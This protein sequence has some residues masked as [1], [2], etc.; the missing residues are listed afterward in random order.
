MNGDDIRRSRERLG[1]TRQDLVEALDPSDAGITLGKLSYIERGNRAP[2]DEESLEL[3]VFFK[4]KFVETIHDTGE[5]KVVALD[6]PPELG[7]VTAHYTE[8]EGSPVDENYELTPLGLKHGDT[9]KV[10]GFR[11]K[12]RFL[13]HRR[14]S[15]GEYVQV[16]GPLG[17][18]GV[19]ERSVKPNRVRKLR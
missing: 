13:S 15:G 5:H 12:F 8:P 9:V 16:Y 18:T 17:R 19:G 4:L 6:V 7:E 14:D 3:K 11:G 10:R 1:L 2:T